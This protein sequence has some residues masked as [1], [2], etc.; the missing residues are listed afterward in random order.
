MG[1]ILHNYDMEVGKMRELTNKELE[2]VSGAGVSEAMALW[3]TS[4]GIG[5]V[6]FGSSWGAVTALTAFG[7]APVTALAMVGLAFAGGYQLLQE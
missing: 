6:S 1:A 4:L 2:E 3:G 7:I 5:T